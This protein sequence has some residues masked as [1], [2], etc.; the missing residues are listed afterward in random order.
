[1]RFEFA[2]A[3]RI[4]FGQGTITEA[5]TTAGSFGDNAL[6]VIGYTSDRA[7]PLLDGLK[8]QGVE[9]HL[10][11]IV[12][13]PTVEMVQQ[14]IAQARKAGCDMV[15][16]M[17]GGSVIDAGKAIAGCLTNPGD[18]YN[19]LEVIG[20]GRALMNAAATFIAIPTTAGTGAEVTANAV[21]QSESHG[22]KV[23][24]RSPLM[25]PKVALIDPL[26]GISMPAHITAATGMDALAQLIEAYVSPKGNPL[27]DSLCREGIRRAA[28]SLLAAYQD[29][30]NVEARTDMSLAALFS[31][32]ALT[33]A[34]LGAVHGIAGPLGGMISIPHG[35]VCA[36]LLPLVMQA[37]LN[38]LR[39]RR[40]S[41]EAVKPY[42]EVAKLLTD[43]ETSS[44]S[45]GVAWVQSACSKMDIGSLSQYGVTP[46]LIA[47]LLP[48]AQKASS[49]QGNPVGLSDEELTEI[50]TAAIG[51]P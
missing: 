16:A 29:G 5:A 47:E 10:E 13:E 20:K 22:V 24:M 17:G 50:L 28:R 6:V 46:A 4:I 45:D 44:A 32:L 25:L 43:N 3:T 27:T 37:N 42:T 34:K 11:K 30:G 40:E 2:T 33:N 23:S 35:V 1:M 18:I 26:L 8:H 51:T 38:A 12:G 15:I 39:D 48:K 9:Y 14:G 49:M 21:L 36:R 31:G 7:E 19:Y 41:D